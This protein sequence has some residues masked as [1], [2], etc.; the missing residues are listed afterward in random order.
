MGPFCSSRE[1]RV[2]MAMTEICDGEKCDENAVHLCQEC[3]EEFI[4]ETVA[5][6]LESNLAA[7]KRYHEKKRRSQPVA[8]DQP[9]ES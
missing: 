7:L 1:R 6:A 4:L 3:L 8:K 9:C 2:I 5:K